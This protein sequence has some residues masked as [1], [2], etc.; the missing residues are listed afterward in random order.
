MKL[1]RG[2][3]GEYSKAGYFYEPYMSAVNYSV[4]EGGPNGKYVGQ[5]TKI[6]AAWWKATIQCGT[7]LN[8]SAKGPTRDKAI[9]KALK[10]KEGM[11]KNELTG[12]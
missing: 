2:V 11:E 10:L 3:K 7:G 1:P 4:R 12:V 8:I 9:L 5:V 6:G